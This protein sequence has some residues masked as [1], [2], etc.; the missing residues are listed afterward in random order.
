MATISSRKE[1]TNQIYSNPNS[2]E[3]KQQQLEQHKHEQHE[4]CFHRHRRRKQII[5]VQKS[6]TTSLSL[7]YYQL[8][9]NCNH[10]KRLMDKNDDYEK[11]SKFSHHSNPLLYNGESTRQLF[12]FLILFL[13]TFYSTIVMTAANFGMSF[14][15][16]VC[17][18]VLIYIVC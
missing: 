12:L 11:Y 1:S 8:K 5:N 2:G 4:Y 15:I 6:S 13:L 16:Y 18:R 3:I 10:F 9:I 17:V 14:S 7:D